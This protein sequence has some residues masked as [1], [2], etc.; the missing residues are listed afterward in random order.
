MEADTVRVAALEL[1]GQQKTWMKNLCSARLHGQISSFSNI[2]FLNSLIQNWHTT[3]GGEALSSFSLSLNN[4]ILVV[5]LTSHCGMFSLNSLCAETMNACLVTTLIFNQTWMESLID[6]R[7]NYSAWGYS[8]DIFTHK[9]RLGGEK[10]NK[11]LPKVVCTKSA[12]VKKWMI[13]NT[14]AVLLANP[15]VIYKSWGGPWRDLALLHAQA[16]A[17]NDGSSTNLWQTPSGAKWVYAKV[18][19]GVF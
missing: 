4:I 19:T 17:V 10:G 3:A 12:A 5:S 14:L 6:L 8:R 15:M 2:C 9:G 7:C 1:C 11:Q 18:K 16:A 13:L